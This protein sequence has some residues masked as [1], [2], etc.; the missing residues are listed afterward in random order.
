MMQDQIQK[1]YACNYANWQADMKYLL[2]ER[3]VSDIV[4]KQKRLPCSMRIAMP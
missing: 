1:L 4:E 3:N 2:I